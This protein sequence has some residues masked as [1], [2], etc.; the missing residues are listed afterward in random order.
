MLEGEYA[1]VGDLI[2]YLGIGRN[3]AYRLVA[4]G[5]IPSIRLGATIRIPV[6]ALKRR[7][8]SAATGSSEK[9]GA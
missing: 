7:L 2:S 8:E 5:E 3:K 6:E 4:S 1:T 9:G